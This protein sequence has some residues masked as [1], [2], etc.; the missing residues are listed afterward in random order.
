MSLNTGNGLENKGYDGLARAARE[1]DR[2][3]RLA[4]M[5]ALG[6]LGDERAIGLLCQGLDE[7]DVE[8]RR[9]AACALYQMLGKRASQVLDQPTLRHVLRFRAPEE[10]LSSPM[11]IRLFLETLDILDSTSASLDIEHGDGAVVSGSPMEGYQVR[12]LRASGAE[13]GVDELVR[14][15]LAFFQSQSQSA[16]GW[17]T[18][19]PMRRTGV[20]SFRQGDRYGETL[21]EFAVARIGEGRYLALT[22][23][24]RYADWD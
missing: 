7:G 18:I 8:L 24:C 10:I 14:R 11:A 15:A 5:Q 21:D 16:D 4:A 2:E 23:H 9:T 3:T 17:W 1:G 19:G 6:K 22:T 12:T 13:L 20:I